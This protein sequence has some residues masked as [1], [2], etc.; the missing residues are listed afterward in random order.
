MK[1]FVSGILPVSPLLG[2]DCQLMCTPP[3]NGNMLLDELRSSKTVKSTSAWQGKHLFW[4]RSTVW[5]F[6]SVSSDVCLTLRTVCEHCHLGILSGGSEVCLML[7]AVSVGDRFVWN[8][9]LTIIKLKTLCVKKNI[10]IPSVMF[11][12][13]QIEE[14]IVHKTFILCCLHL[15]WMFF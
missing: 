6:L 11:T 13:L 3:W 5:A 7:R 9:V 1:P 14:H 4:A 12:L 10:F 2:T 8:S 15:T